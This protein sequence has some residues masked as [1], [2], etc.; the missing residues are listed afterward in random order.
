MK[1]KKIVEAAEV[2]EP[3]AVEPDAINTAA[4]PVQC[5]AWC[6]LLGVAGIFCALEKEHEGEHKT[7][8]QSYAE[9]QSRFTVTWELT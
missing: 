1:R 5:G 3:E 9:P 2:V 4:P 8:I 7:S 6:F